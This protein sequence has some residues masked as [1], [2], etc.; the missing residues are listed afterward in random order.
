ML[1]KFFGLYC[2]QSLGKNI[3]LVVMNNLL[4]STIPMHVKYD[5][6]GSTYKRKAAKNERNK[7]SPTLKDNDFVEENR[8]GF[9][10]VAATLD[11]LLRTIE[12]DC[13]VLE[14]FKS[15]DYSLLI[16][17]HNIAQDERDHRLVR[18]FFCSPLKR[19]IA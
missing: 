6:K 12:R 5:L 17:V 11:A 15:M 1:P 2:Y 18:D 16:G 10:L 7:L 14:S 4:P 19:V 8:D 13:L 3:R 9:F